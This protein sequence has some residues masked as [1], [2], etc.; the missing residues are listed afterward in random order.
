MNGIGIGFAV[1][2]ARDARKDRVVRSIDVTVGTGHPFAIV[3][4]GVNGEPCVVED[5]SQPGGR[6][7]TGGAGCRK[8]GGLMVWIGRSQVIGLVA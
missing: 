2:V 6:R 7:V 4:S 1:L 5:R 3:R 8:V